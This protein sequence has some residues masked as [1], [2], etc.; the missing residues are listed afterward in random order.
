MNGA[1]HRRHQRIGFEPPLQSA[2]NT[3][4]RLMNRDEDLAAEDQ[5]PSRDTAVRIKSEV[6]A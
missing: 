4:A 2:G 3:P 5:F 1:G 6:P